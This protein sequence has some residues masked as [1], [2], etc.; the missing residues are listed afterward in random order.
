MDDTISWK[1]I[2]ERCKRAAL[3]M[4]PDL[5]T[6]NTLEAWQDFESALE[7]AVD[8][9]RDSAWQEVESWDWAIYTWCGMEII[10]TLDSSELSDAEQEWADCNSGA[11]DGVY[12]Y[13]S[14]VAFFA[15]VR[16]LQEAVESAA[17]DL[18]ELAANQ[19]GNLETA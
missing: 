19:V 1:A 12:E 16:K 11:P 6:A 8:D 9:A 2:D 7:S 15:L 14:Q 3:E 10:R 17:D 4:L 13:A 5:P 18:R